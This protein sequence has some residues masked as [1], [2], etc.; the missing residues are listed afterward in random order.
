MKLIGD[1]LYAASD[2]GSYSVIDLSIYSRDYCELLN[3]IWEQVP[4]VWKSGKPVV[5]KPS[6][7]HPC[8]VT[9]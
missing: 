1:K 6:P 3:E 2:I 5:E 9:N 4:I 8:A 7:D